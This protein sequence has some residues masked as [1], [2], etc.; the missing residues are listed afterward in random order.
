MEIQ[1]LSAEEIH[2]EVPKLEKGEHTIVFKAEYDSPYVENLI[3]NKAKEL[4]LLCI[5]QLG[6]EK[7][8]TYKLTEKII[9]VFLTCWHRYCL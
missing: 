9:I 8:A 6:E 3:F 4:D 1:F 7:Y 5:R 2:N